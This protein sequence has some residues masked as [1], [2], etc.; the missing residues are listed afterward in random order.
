MEPKTALGR[1]VGALNAGVASLLDLPLLGR[2]LGKGFVVITYVGRR[3]GRTFRTPV[4]YRRKGDELVIGVAM[5]DKKS[6]W[7]NFLD[8]GGPITLRLDGAERHGHAV[9]QRDERGRVL[10]KV[11]LNDAS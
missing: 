6:W 10:V 3:S 1:S 4:N 7:R 11:R 2:L 5:P 8:D 9:A